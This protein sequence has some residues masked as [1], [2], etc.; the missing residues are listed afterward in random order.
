ML[1]SILNASLYVS[2]NP[3]TY[4]IYR[5]T[6]VQHQADK[7]SVR[8]QKTV[9]GDF[10]GAGRCQG[11]AGQERRTRKVSEE[12][13]GPRGGVGSQRPGET[14]PHGGRMAVAGGQAVG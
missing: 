14:K 10:Q 6:G 12:I 13:R 11:D 3:S 7:Y 5:R 9:R 8:V 2:V 4:A 1:I